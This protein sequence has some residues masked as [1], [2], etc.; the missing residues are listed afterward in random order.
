MDSAALRACSRACASARASSC[1]GYIPSAAA[2][3]T[4]V[5][6]FTSRCERSIS[7]MWF[8]ASPARAASSAWERSLSRRSRR[9]VLPNARRSDRSLPSSVE[10]VER[11]VSS[12]VTE[13]SLLRSG[14][15]GISCS[16]VPCSIRRSLL[17]LARPTYDPPAL[18][19]T[20]LFR[21][22]GL[23]RTED[24]TASSTVHHARHGHRDSR[25][26][27]GLRSD[28]PRAGVRSSASRTALREVHGDHP[29]HDD[30]VP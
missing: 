14:R 24:R 27:A 1:Q 21:V 17:A 26:P 10:N 25:H 4:I 13:G 6:S 2:S 5:C 16:R 23:P 29:A 20:P 30:E 22:L 18:S 28:R 19:G 12:A 11:P 8:C 9:I 15:G 7:P 3:D